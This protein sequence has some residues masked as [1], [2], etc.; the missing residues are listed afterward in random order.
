MQYEYNKKVVFF[1]TR[2]KKRNHVLP[3]SKLR[4]IQKL[5]TKKLSG[6]KECLPLLPCKYINA[7]HVAER[8]SRFRRPA[9]DELF[10]F[11]LKMP[12]FRTNGLQDG[13]RGIW[14]CWGGG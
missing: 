3:A 8:N 2:K 11:V 9:S 6:E 12:K 5:D 14:W 1:N 7:R 10:D 13:C 4:N